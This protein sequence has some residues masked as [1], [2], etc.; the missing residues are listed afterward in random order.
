MQLIRCLLSNFYLNIF[1]TSLCPSSGE[2]D[3]GLPHMVFC[4]GCA[5]CGWLQL[6]TTTVNHNQH[7]QCR[8]PYVIVHGLVLLMMGIM[9]PET[10]WD[11]SLIINIGLVAFCCF[12]C[13]HP[14]F[15][16]HGHKNLKPGNTILTF[17]WTDWL[18]TIWCISA[19][20]DRQPANF[21]TEQL[22]SRGENRYR[23]SRRGTLHNIIWREIWRFVDSRSGMCGSFPSG[24]DATSLDIQ[25]L[26]CRLR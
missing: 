10:C 9:M 2:Q 15:M 6:H 21:R 4:T 12:L 3:R 19:R 13:L 11:K 18:R 1:R 24:Y 25:F 5:G 7:N 20:M 22:P 26:K 23:V 14:T 16:M 8:T 17:G